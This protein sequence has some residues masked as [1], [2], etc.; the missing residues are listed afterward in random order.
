MSDR[1]A[2]Y[3]VRAKTEERIVLEDVGPW[4]RYMTITNA[5]ESVVAEVERDYGIGS[6]RLFYYDSD[7]EM[8]ELLVK[9]GQFAG[10]AAVLTG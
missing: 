3:V 6:R 5:A 7:G 2:N 10:F 1:K 9:N 4:D 8:T